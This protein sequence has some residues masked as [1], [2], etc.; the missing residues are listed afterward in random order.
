MKT[1]NKLLLGAFVGI[2]AGCIAIL[3]VI[4]LSL[5]DFPTHRG[6]A[7]KNTRMGLK[8]IEM[9]GFNGVDLKG[10]WEARIV[11]E[12]QEAIRVKGPEDLLAGLW[13]NRYGNFIELHMAKQKND[14]RKLRLEMTLPVIQSLRTK[15]V[16]DVSISGFDLDGLVIDTEGVSSIHGKRGRALKFNF[17]GRG[18]SN[19][20]LED[21]PTR[22]ADLN[23]KG[24]VNID[25]TMDGG[26]LSGNIKGV[27]NV[28]YKGTANRESLRVKGA[29]QV[30]AQL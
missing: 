19:L 9:T 21:F 15:G 5:N 1:S 24:V 27:G 28:R 12:G 26:E 3:I 30:T 11:R 17:R 8:E 16:A 13:V 22:N 23:C 20:D 7:I 10:N 6:S 25:L 4:K 14:D 2:I 18:V 29:C